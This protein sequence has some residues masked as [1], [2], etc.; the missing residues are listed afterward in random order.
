MNTTASR[1]V[2]RLLFIQFVAGLLAHLVILAFAPRLLLLDTSVVVATRPLSLWS[3]WTGFILEA[4][5]TLLLTRKLRAP[6]RALGA[7]SAEVQPGDVLSL[8]ALPARIVIMDTICATV[9]ASATLV[10]PFRPPTNDLNTQASIILLALT[11]VSAATLPLYVTLRSSVA[12][13]LELVPVAVSRDAL[14]LMDLRQRRVAHVRQRLVAAVAAPVAFV[15]LG[16]SLLVHAHVRVFDTTA[17]ED[18]AQKLATAAL[19]LI[20]KDASGR[21]EAVA[22][23]LLHGFRIKLDR[24]SA[25][26]SSTRDDEGETELF[27]PLDDGHAIMHF[28]TARLSPVTWIYGLLAFIAVMLAAILGSRIGQG[29]VADVALAARQV[30]ATGAADVIRGT[31]VRREARFG[32]VVSLLDAIDEL[33]G[34]FREFASAQEHAIEARAA[35]ERM[36]GLFLAA[37][38]HDLKGPLNAILGFAGLVS[39]S[40]LSEGQQE[41][42]AIIE[43]RGRELLTLIQTI[44]DS[45]RVEAGE[46]EV[47]PE[48]TMVGDVVMSAVL[49]AR[50]LLV[51]SGVEVVGEIQP[52]VPKLYVDAAR[53]VQ[54]L[55]AV[56]ASAVRFTEKG[57]VHV[58][59]TLSAASESLR[60][61]V[62]SSGRTVPTAE[63]EKVF[64]AFKDPDRARRH[65]SLGLGLSLARS[66]LEIHSGAIDVAAAK[67]GGAVFHVSLPTSAER[68]AVSVV[69]ASSRRQTN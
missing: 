17:R 62:E 32:S 69:M 22:A 25:P 55:T 35:T 37:M 41:S 49:E 67:G 8:Y 65:G 10:P 68:V 27:V 46:L 6:L 53:I 23:A 56:I 40:R 1:L 60:I 5:A 50:E 24:D 58:R 54:A 42:L 63:L 33:G 16:A 45:A 48:W 26:Y 21:N 13:V 28:E 52:G 36:R 51:G 39:R 34:V 9:V 47:T 3:G 19:D 66:I 38:S 11:I 18:D 2:P 59:A 15:A 7:G 29:F 31:R 57:V 30:R 64:E 4:V 14:T 61:N 20:G 12:R 43:Q 44:L